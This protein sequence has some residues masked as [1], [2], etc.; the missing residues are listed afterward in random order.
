GQARDLGGVAYVGTEAPEGAAGNDVRTLAQEIRGRIDPAR[1]AVV[2]V[3]SRSNGKASLIVAVNATAK[4]RGLS[5]SDLVKG[6]LSGRGGGNA[7]LAQGGGVAA[8]QVPALLSA[9]EKA[10]A[11]A[12]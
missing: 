11:E 12:V 2:A 9:V 6:A 3:A 10:V 4:G 7:D 1:P 5:A 8:D